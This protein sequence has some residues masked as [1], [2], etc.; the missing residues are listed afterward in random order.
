MYR[1]Q[2]EDRKVARK[3]TDTYDPV[4]VERCERLAQLFEDFVSIEEASQLLNMSHDCARDKV[5]RGTLAGV[6]VG[7]SSFIHKSEIVRVRSKLTTRPK[8]SAQPQ[9]KQAS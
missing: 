2:Q 8:L 5:R 1:K 6:R 7:G 9:R 4:A 3:L